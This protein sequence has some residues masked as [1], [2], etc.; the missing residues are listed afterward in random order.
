VRS[1]DACHGLFETRRFASEARGSDERPRRKNNMAARST[2]CSSLSAVTTPWSVIEVRGATTGRVGRNAATRWPVSD[3]RG[4][5]NRPRRQEALSQWIK[6]EECRDS[7]ACGGIPVVPVAL[8]SDDA[9][10]RESGSGAQEQAAAKENSARGKKNTARPIEEE[11]RGTGKSA[12]LRKSGSRRRNLSPR[13]AGNMSR[14]SEESAGR[15]RERSL[16]RED[17]CRPAIFDTA[18]PKE[19]TRRRGEVTRRPREAARRPGE[20]TRRS[21]EVTRRPREATRRSR[22][23]TQRAGCTICD[24]NPGEHGKNCVKAKSSRSIH[25]T[26]RAACLVRSPSPAE[27]QPGAR[28]QSCRAVKR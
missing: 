24:R 6:E 2:S 5:E 16:R 1:N 8:L 15:S 23:A 28:I 4:R 12:R 17:S 18:R 26:S 21:G 11:A 9:A 3:P 13:R 20:R 14:R 7:C 27:S 25:W 10:V 19:L 22:A